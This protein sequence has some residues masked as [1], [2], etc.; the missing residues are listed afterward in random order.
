MSRRRKGPG[1]TPTSSTIPSLS[2]PHPPKPGLSFYPFPTNKRSSFTPRRPLGACVSVC[3]SV[4]PTC[5]RPTLGP[6]QGWGCS[7]DWEPLPN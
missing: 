5:P 4:C 7:R 1:W 2:L 3:L 6:G